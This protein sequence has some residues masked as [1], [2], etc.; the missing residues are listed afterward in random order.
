MFHV[1]H[2]KTFTRVARLDRAVHL[3]CMLVLAEETDGHLV[4]GW[5]EELQ[6][7]IGATGRAPS[8]KEEVAD[9]DP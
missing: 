6:Q 5:R 2:K 4:P 9:E 1:K 3:V 7:L 8:V